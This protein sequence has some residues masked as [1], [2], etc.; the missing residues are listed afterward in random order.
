M[1]EEVVNFTIGNIN[2]SQSGLADFTH[3]SKD[4]SCDEL[5]ENK[6]PLL[7]GFQYRPRMVND[8]FV[9]LEERE[10]TGK[11]T[12]ILLDS[13]EGDS[14]KYPLSHDKT[15]THIQANLEQ[16]HNSLPHLSQERRLVYYVTTLSYVI[17]LAE[18]ETEYG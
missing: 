10:A 14:I 13:T 3:N 11:K 17:R 16:L 7:V 5:F 8:L 15:A 4:I 2:I 12:T 6:S 1:L 9:Y 18:M